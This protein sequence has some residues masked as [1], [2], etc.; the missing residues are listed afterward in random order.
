VPRLEDE[1]LLRGNGRFIDDL[2]MPGMLEAAF[3]RSPHAHAL[4]R[5]IRKDAALALNGVHAV[6]VRDDVLPHLR[7]EFIVVGLPSKDYKQDLNR[8][9][10]IGDEAVYVGQPVAMV[11][12]E[13]RYIAEDAAAL[14]R[15]GLGALPAAA[16]CKAALSAARPRSTADRR[17][18]FLPNSRWDTE[19]WGRICLREAR[20]QGILLAAS[21]RKSLDRVPRDH[22]LARPARWPPDRVDLDPD[23]PRRIARALRH[24]G[25]DEDSIRVVTPD[26]GGGFGPK[27][28]STPRTSALRSP[29]SFSSGR[30]NGSRT[31]SSILSRRRRS[32]IST[33]T[34]RLPSM[35]RRACS[36]F[37]AR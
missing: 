4:V 24:A 33:G 27:L 31:A 5:G 21:W 32:A 7:N 12:A 37:A 23:A 28:V 10:L 16:D 1:P 17:T 34:S 6:L 25:P 29:P 9:A 11:V 13:N 30:S 8:P 22:C 18:I 3:V 26:V 36:E 2:H 35:T 14:D 19:T 20:V 15:G